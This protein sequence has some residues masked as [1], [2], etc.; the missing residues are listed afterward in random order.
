MDDKTF[1]VKEIAEIFRVNE[2][3]VYTW[4]NKNEIPHMRLGGTIRFHKEHLEAI[5]KRVSGVE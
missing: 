4:V 1:T 5:R 2:R 3:T